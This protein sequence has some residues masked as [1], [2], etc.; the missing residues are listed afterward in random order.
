[1]R[2]L[3]QE[4]AEI[5]RGVIAKS[6][7]STSVDVNELT[8]KVHVAIN[9]D[10]SSEDSILR[11]TTDESYSLSVTTQLPET[12]VNIVASTFFGARH[13]LETLSQ[14]MA[15]DESVGSMIMLSHATITDSPAFVHR[16]VMI[17]SSRNFITIDVIKKIIDAMSYDKLNV[18][19]WHLTDTQ[20]FPLV[21][22]RQPLMALYGAYSPEKVYR[23]E[24]IQ[25]IVRYAMVRGVKVVP[26]LNTPA[27][28]GS[29]WEWG[30]KNG[31][32][33]LVLCVNKEPVVEYCYQPPCGLL[34]PVNENI[35]PILN[36][37]YRDMSELFQSDI[38]HMGGDEVKMR[39]WNES[40]EV[41]DWLT[42]QGKQDRSYADFIQLW[43][44]FQ[45]RAVEELDKAYGRQLPIVLWTSGLTEDGEADKYLDKDRYIIHIWTTATDQSIANLYRQGFQ[46]ILS[47][48]DAW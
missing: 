37:I 9:I 47:N 20:S 30:E 16:G 8:S 29:G 33:Q 28:T 22:P 3:T 34:N 38:F 21:S 36:N 14:L 40:Q 19:H 12:S 43:L 32:G 2:T 24:D 10:I 17:D 6:I 31:L 41:V 18:L 44:H 15:W 46:L 25:G 42:S 26:E 1:M 35:Y 13:A 45:R 39:C 48:V 4:A 11:M 27:H 23:P 7:P 5:F